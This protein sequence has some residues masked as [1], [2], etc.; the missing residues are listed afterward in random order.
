MELGG[1]I[2]KTRM[3]KKI[4]MRELS[5]QSGVTVS[6]LSNIENNKL[7][8]EPNVEIVFDLLKTLEVPEPHEKMVEL[9]L[10]E[11]EQI[12]TEETYD[13]AK[14]S[15]FKREIELLMDGMDTE[16]LESLFLLLKEHF[17][18]LEL[19]SSVKDKKASLDLFET[20]IKFIQYQ[21]DKKIEQKKILHQNQS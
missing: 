18:I 3:Q 5:R 2:R 13:R 14:R 19:L 6:Y 15:K 10:V 7:G 12:T 8:Y 4:S 1:F 11:K 20:Y 9:G 17:N 21:E 16:E